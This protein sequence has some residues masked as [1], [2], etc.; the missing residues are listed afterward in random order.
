MACKID[1]LLPD[2]EVGPSVMSRPQGVSA[3]PLSSASADV[4]TVSGNRL[5]RMTTNRFRGTYLT[6][7]YETSCT[8]ERELSTHVLLR[9]GVGRVLEALGKS[10]RR[11]ILIELRNGHGVREDDLV[12]RGGKSDSKRSEIALKHTDLPKLA[13][14]EYIEWN[15]DTGELSKGPRFGEIEP[16]L[17]LIER[18]GDD[19]PQDWP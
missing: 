7:C 12:M 11:R 3:A 4:V 1:Y 13:D 5:V 14:M 15:P 19:L 16:L 17:A 18:H 2:R 6:F 8:M 10:Q 9:P